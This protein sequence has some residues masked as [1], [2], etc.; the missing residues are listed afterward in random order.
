MAGNKLTIRL[1][2]EQQNQIRN[3]TG[4]NITEL[5][6]DLAATGHL[7]EKDLSEVSGGIVIDKWKQD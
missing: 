6:I 1:T 4:K 3:A 5:N 2:D 7:S